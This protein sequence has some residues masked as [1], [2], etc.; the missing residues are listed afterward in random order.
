MTARAYCF[1][2]NNP[3]GLPDFED[4]VKE[5]TVR[6]AVFQLEMGESGTTH[7][8]GYLELSSP[9]RITYVKS[10][11]GLETAH[12]EKRRGTPEQARQYCMKKDETYLEGPWEYGEFTKE[13]GKRNDLAEVY[14]LVKEGKKEVEILEANPSAY[15]R[16]YRGIREAKRIVQMNRSWPTEVTVIYGAPGLGKSAMAL[17]HLGND[18]YWKPRGDWWDGY[19]GQEN[20]VIDEF[21]GWIPWDTLMKILDRYPLMVPTKGGFANFLAKKVYI[22]SNKHPK[23]WYDSRKFPFP[24]LERRVRKWYYFQETVVTIKENYKDFEVITWRD[25]PQ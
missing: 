22:I 15:I 10:I 13:Q 19:E 25:F 24:A 23:D 4:F 5:K 21:Y 16:Y 12:V 9:R 1:T 7:L 14:A 2:V 3:D 8:Q 20:V 17:K 6:Y 11:P 18:A